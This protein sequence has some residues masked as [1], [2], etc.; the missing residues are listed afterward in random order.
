[1]SYSE[2]NYFVTQWGTLPCRAAADLA[3]PQ[4]VF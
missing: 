1:M 2:V 3:A 4:A